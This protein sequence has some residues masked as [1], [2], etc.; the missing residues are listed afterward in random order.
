MVTEGE[1]VVSTLSFISSTH[2]GSS[3]PG[4]TCTLCD[5]MNHQFCSQQSL[6]TVGK[7]ILSR[8][9]EALAQGNQGEEDRCK[10]QQPLSIVTSVVPQSLF[11]EGVSCEGAVQKVL[12]SSPCPVDLFCDAGVQEEQKLVTLGCKKSRSFDP[13]GQGSQDT[14]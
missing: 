14:K 10:L 8:S 5:T 9:G 7:W 11:L 12:G 1:T 13:G 6:T 4:L 2:F 3:H